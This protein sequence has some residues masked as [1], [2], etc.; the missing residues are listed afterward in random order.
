MA[1][2]PR[3]L[4]GSDG[5]RWWTH[6]GDLPSSPADRARGDGRRRGGCLHVDREPAAGGVVDVGSGIV[7]SYLVRLD[8]VGNSGDVG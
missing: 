3:A 4:A 6:D 1:R 8:V 7:I 5:R 2:L